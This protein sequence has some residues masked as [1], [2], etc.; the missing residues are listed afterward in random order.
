ML[1]TRMRRFYAT[2]TGALESDGWSVADSRFGM[3][4][5]QAL[6]R[7]DAEAICASLNGERPR[8]VPFLRL[9]PR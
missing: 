8:A 5:A 4:V 7:E 1:A 6:D 9:V 3:F 2:K